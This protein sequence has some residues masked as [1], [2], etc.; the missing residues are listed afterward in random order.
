MSREF[1][2]AC[3]IPMLLMPGDDVVHPAPVSAELARA[4]NAQVLAP[5]KGVERRAAAMQRVREFL[6]RHTP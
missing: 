2:R 1:V 6:I 4:P 5:W 3:R